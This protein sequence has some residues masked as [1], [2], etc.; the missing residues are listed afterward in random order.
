[1]DDKV[2]RTHGSKASLEQAVLAGE[3]IGKGVRGFIGK[4][5]ARRDSNP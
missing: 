3:Q 2:I 5:R 1:M 4:W